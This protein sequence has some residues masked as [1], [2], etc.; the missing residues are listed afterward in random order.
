MSAVNTRIAHFPNVALSLPHSLS[1]YL[2]LFIIGTNPIGDFMVVAVPRNANNNS[3]WYL[4]CI[5][6]RYGWLGIETIEGNRFLVALNEID[7]DVL[8]A[9]SPERE[10]KKP[11]LNSKHEQ[12]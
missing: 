9:T 2:Y 11:R 10:K 1:L 5:A 7:G 3:K 8:T 12:E 6:H 4:K